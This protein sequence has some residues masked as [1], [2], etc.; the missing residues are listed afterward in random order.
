MS[1]KVTLSEWY[2]YS[3]PASPSRASKSIPEIGFKW[4]V[5]KIC[6][7]FSVLGLLASIIKTSFSKAGL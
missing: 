3:S 4:S 1:N 7:V 6:G 2:A 5:L